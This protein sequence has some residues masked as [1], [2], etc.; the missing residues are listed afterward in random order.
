M[1]RRR[2]RSPFETSLLACVEDGGGGLVWIRLG[3]SLLRRE[4]SWAEGM[5]LGLYAQ[6]TLLGDGFIF[7]K[8]RRANS[9]SSADN[10]LRSILLSNLFMVSS[11]MYVLIAMPTETLMYREWRTGRM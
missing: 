3:E 2:I 4:L 1:S 5:D 11:T 10:H 7:T 6:S 8:E 9:D